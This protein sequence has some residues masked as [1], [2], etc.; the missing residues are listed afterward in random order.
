M[1]AGNRCQRD[2]SKRVRPL[3]AHLVFIGVLHRQLQITDRRG[4]APGARRSNQG[5]RGGVD[6]RRG[7]HGQTAQNWRVTTS[8]FV[9]ASAPVR[10]IIVELRYPAPYAADTLSP[11][12]GGSPFVPERPTRS[13]PIASTSIVSKRV[14]TSGLRYRGPPIS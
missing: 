9:L 10:P 14:V 4:I 7:S 1:V 11:L 2:L 8:A 5:R 13:G 12:G 3:S 6:S